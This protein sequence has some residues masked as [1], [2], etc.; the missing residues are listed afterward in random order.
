MRLLDKWR[1]SCFPEDAYHSSCVLVSNACAGYLAHPFEKLVVFLERI[2]QVA[3]TGHFIWQ[4]M[5]PLWKR[6][7]KGKCHSMW[8]I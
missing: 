8:Q 1:I 5:M 6:L 4:K 2:C 3:S 7:Y